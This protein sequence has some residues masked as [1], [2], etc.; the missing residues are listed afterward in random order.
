MD[1]LTQIALGAAIGQAGLGKQHRVRGAVYGAICGTLPDLDVLWPMADPVASFTYH[2]GYSHS[3]LVLSLLAPVIVWLIRRFDRKA[4]GSW[5]RWLAV[6]WLVLITHP[7]LDSLT[8]Y[9]TQIFLPFSNYPVSGSAIFIIDPLYTVPLLLAVAVSLSRAVPLSRVRV[10]MIGLSVSSLYLCFAVAAKF[11]VES[12][13]ADDHLARELRPTVRVS[14]PAPL[15]TLVWRVV[16]VLPGGYEVSFVRPFG[17][18][19]IASQYYPSTPKLLEPVADSWAVQRLQWF[20][21]GA[22]RVRQ[23][24]DEVVITDLRMGLEDGYAFSFAV[25]RNDNGRIVAIAPKAIKPPELGSE[26][27]ERLKNVFRVTRQS[28]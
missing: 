26:M 5:Q 28:T 27:I 12:R 3:L 9:G 14:T 21:H 4:M 17:M 19:Q 11:S 1:S 10:A 13:I 8:V 23:E 22:Y 16:S 24:G 18:G 6:I 15:T 7:L 20:T 2:R 25:A